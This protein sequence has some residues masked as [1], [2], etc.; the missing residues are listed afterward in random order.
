MTDIVTKSE[1]E[2]IGGSPEKL[3]EISFTTK[4]ITPEDK[5][6][7]L[8][9]GQLRARVYLEKGYINEAQLD[10]NG[11][12][13]DEMDL[14]SNHF[15]AIDEDDEVIGT[16]RVINRVD[17]GKL[18]SEEEFDVDLPNQ[19]HEISRLIRDPELSNE[20]GLLVS[21]S[22]MRAALKATQESEKVYA[23]LE[24]KLH[25]QLSYHIGIG[26]SDVVPP[27]VIEHYNSTLNH[28][29]EIE[30]RYVTSQV[31]ERDERVYAQARNHPALQ[32]SILGKP[33]A[34]FF[35]QNSRA[36]GL[37]RVSLKDLT[38]PNP[39][40]F[41]RNGFYSQ[42]EQKMIWESTV[43]IA[44]AGGDGGELAIT[45]AQ[46]GVRSFKLADPENFGIENFNRQ[47]GA[48]YSTIGHNKAE[49]IAK[50]LRALGASVEIYSEGITVD[51]IEEFIAGS[52]LVIDE[53]EFTMP[54]LGVMIAR[55]ARK[56]ELPV[57]MALNVGF[58]SYVTSFHPNGMRFEDYLG[59]DPSLS[60]DEITEK[61]KEKPISISKWAPHIPSYANVDI[62][63]KVATNEITAPTVSQGVRMAAADAG[64]VAVAHLLRDINPNWDKWIHWAPTGNVNDAKDGTMVVRSRAWHFAVSVAKASLGTR[65]GKSHP[66]K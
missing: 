62:L 29:V 55:E 21:L 35:E 11:A 50:R 38:S 47:A 7:W 27:K 8:G 6:L 57:L 43:A 24:A 65:L 12:E 3:T 34:P 48:D 30:P 19:T 13:Y 60:I 22:M 51:N 46:A 31:Y 16:V 39:E 41:I 23:I 2:I 63:Q 14:S 44:G 26:L 20:I 45:L 58:G 28:L 36:M 40:Q 10:A 64:S 37:G 66:S 32:E 52:T 25:R 33:F 1:N 17:S 53:T 9:M 42:E 59:I 15:V 5:E 56:N 54:E 18:P 4:Y 49:V 61:F